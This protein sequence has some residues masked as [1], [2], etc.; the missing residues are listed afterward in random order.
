MAFDADTR[1]TMERF[2]KWSNANAI[3]DADYSVVIDLLSRHDGERS[4]LFEELLNHL[5]REKDAAS[6]WQS[7]ADKGL[8]LNDKLNSAIAAKVPD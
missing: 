6:P 7:T 3:L 1:K 4:K 8:E 2:Q 5:K